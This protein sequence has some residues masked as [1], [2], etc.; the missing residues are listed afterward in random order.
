MTRRSF[1]F[2][3][4]ALSAVP[5]VAYAQAD[6]WQTVVGPDLRFRLEMPAPVNKS[7]AAEKEKGHTGERL[8]WASKRADE[9]FDFDYVDYEPGWFSS[10]DGKEMARELGRGE[11]EK[12]FPRAKF[13]Y[14]LDEPV[15]LQGWD[16]YALD[17]ADQQGSLVMMRTYIVKD[18][19]YR[20]LVTAKNDE[21]TKAAATRFL[22]SLRFAETKS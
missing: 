18:R 20:L 2:A 3:A 4:P 10:K 15:T 17:I 7:S 11:A 14:V 5:T 13:K 16:G 9:M 1:V 8:A 12:A 6:Q 22:G 19:L 21:D